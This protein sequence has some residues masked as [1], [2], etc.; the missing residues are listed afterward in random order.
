MLVSGVR[1]KSRDGD[2]VVF[3]ME[4]SPSITQEKEKTTTNRRT[5]RRE[6]LKR[7]REREREREREKSS[8]EKGNEEAKK[9]ENKKRPYPDSQTGNERT[10]N[11]T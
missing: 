2:R 9:K 3:E 4:P 5:Q 8:E 10:T 7:T 6:C 11:A 1:G